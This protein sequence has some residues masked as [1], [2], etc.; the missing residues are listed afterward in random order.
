MPKAPKKRH[1]VTGTCRHAYCKGLR[2]GIERGFRQGVGYAVAEVVRA[3]DQP[4]MAADVASAAGFTYREYTVAGLDEY[5]LKT[6]RK[7]QRE[8]RQF[9]KARA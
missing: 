9:P 1:C 5:D 4:G 7:L 6:L 3:H 8:E 2:E